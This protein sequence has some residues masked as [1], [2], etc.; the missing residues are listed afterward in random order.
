[1]PATGYRGLGLY[2]LHHQ[3]PQLRRIS[4]AASGKLDDLSRY[5][6]TQGIFWLSKF[7]LAAKILEGTIASTCS[8]SNALFSN[9]R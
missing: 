5:N 1:V 9:S 2:C 7:K 6:F 3:D 8:G 4:L